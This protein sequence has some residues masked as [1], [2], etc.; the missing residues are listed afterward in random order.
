MPRVSLKI[1][2]INQQQSTAPGI[3][4]AMFEWIFFRKISWFEV[5][6]FG[7]ASLVYW[8]F[9]VCLCQGS[10]SEVTINDWLAAIVGSIFFP[11][12]AILAW[13]HRRRFVS[14]KKF[15]ATLPRPLHFE[16]IRQQKQGVNR[17]KWRAARLAMLTESL[18][19]KIDLAEA[20]AIVKG[21]SQRPAS[22]IPADE[23]DRSDFQDFIAE[24]L[25]TDAELWLYDCAEN[26]SAG[27]AVVHAGQVKDVLRL[28]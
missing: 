18:V 14:D 22:W 25:P 23:A 27:L 9:L 26:G 4:N 7:M 28:S 8:I 17:E 24:N 5:A 13:Q 19:R 2:A 21:E 20:E 6:F 15:E 16:W 3:R 12:F 1:A 10:V 11:A